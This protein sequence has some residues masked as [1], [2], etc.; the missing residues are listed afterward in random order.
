MGP[1]VDLG[2]KLLKISSDFLFPP[3]SRL[4]KQVSEVSLIS[5]QIVNCSYK[6]LI[7]THSRS[8][9]IEV[10]PYL[11]VYSYGKLYDSQ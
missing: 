8:N 1:K 3:R 11:I 5:V 6:S 4:T 9:K 10:E 7:N 2:F